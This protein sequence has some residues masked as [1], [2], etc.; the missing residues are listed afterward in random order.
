M[1]WD[2]SNTAGTIELWNFWQRKQQ[3]VVFDDFLGSN[4]HH[5]S[6]IRNQITEGLWNY[7]NTSA[8]E[9]S[10]I[11]KDCHNVLWPWDTQKI[12]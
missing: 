6:A 8:D 5:Q 1:P 12:M 11:W 3:E 10:H 7:S 2:K 4:V 9:W